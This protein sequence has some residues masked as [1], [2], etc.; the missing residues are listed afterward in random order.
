LIDTHVDFGIVQHN[1]G[2]AGNSEMLGGPRIEG[3]KSTLNADLDFTLELNLNMMNQL[4]NA[5]V[6]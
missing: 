1:A 6:A 3:Q 5:F 4:L 2:L